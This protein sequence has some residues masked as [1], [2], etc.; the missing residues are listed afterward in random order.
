MASG[1]V[2]YNACMHDLANGLQTHIYAPLGLNIRGKWTLGGS[3]PGEPVAPI[4]LGMGVPLTGL[5][6]REDVDM[7][8][9]FMLTSFVKG[10]IKKSH[11]TLVERLVSK[12]KAVE[13]L[14]GEDDR[15][16]RGFGEEG[17][18]EWRSRE[19]S[20]S[21]VEAWA[22]N[23]HAGLPSPTESRTSTYQVSEFSTEDDSLRPRP[24][25]IVSNRTNQSGSRTGA[26]PW[27]NLQPASRMQQQRTFA[28]HVRHRSRSPA[29]LPQA[30]HRETAE[31]PQADHYERKTYEMA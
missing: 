9:N 4:E 2:T 28:E 19:E 26:Q 21:R 10:N 16:G 7:R 3:L 1:K 30:D 23:T 13:S 14:R 8:C 31:L 17:D 15:M 20:R 24:L 18:E 12:A 6:I 27:Q 29:E 5:W 25:S 11:A 22:A